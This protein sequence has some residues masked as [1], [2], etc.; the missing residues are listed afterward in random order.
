M[1]VQSQTPTPVVPAKSRGPYSAGSHFGLPLTH[2]SGIGIVSI[3]VLVSDLDTISLL[4]WSVIAIY[5]AT[6][7]TPIARTRSSVRVPCMDIGIANAWDACRILGDRC[8]IIAFAFHLPLGV[9]SALM[10]RFVPLAPAP[11]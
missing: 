3:P 2:Y 5:Y 10:C 9:E 1:L 11:P 8:F 4:L 6:C 7:S